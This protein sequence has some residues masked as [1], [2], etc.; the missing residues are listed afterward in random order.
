MSKV[1]YRTLKYNKDVFC[2][3]I[4]E[5]VDCARILIEIT[6]ILLD[7]GLNVKEEDVSFPYLKLEQ[8]EQSRVFVY[9]DDTKFYSLAYAFFL[10]Y[11]LSTDQIEEIKTY[12]GH[13]CNYETLSKALTILSSP[14][15]ESL[16]DLYLNQDPEDKI[17]EENFLV[18]QYFYI[19]DFGY[20]RYDYD[21]QHVNGAL[22]PLNH[23]DVNYMNYAHYKLG[24]DKRLTPS[25][26]EDII[27]SQS[28]CYF[29]RN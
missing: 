1:V 6:R 18:C 2:I 27:S 12:S 9:L 22:H 15:I 11:N 16:I 21:P 20:I 13:L 26:F 7:E 29:L 24:F 19:S 17:S 28:A 10:N 23:F 25:E 3:A 14:K 8:G 5:R 4:R